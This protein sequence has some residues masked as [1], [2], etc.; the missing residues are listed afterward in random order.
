MKFDN[1][2][3]FD[4]HF[5]LEREAF[6]VNCDGSPAKT[7][8]PF[9]KSEHVDRDF[10]ENQTELITPVC[11]SIKSMLKSLSD[12]D[13]AIKRKL[14]GMGEYLWMNSNPP[15]I[16]TDE[17]IPIAR[18]EGDMAFK[19][20]YRIKL[21][22]R[23]GKRFMLYSGIHFNF[24]FSDRFIH[25]ANDKGEDFLTF[26]NKLYFRLMK[27]AARYSW[28]PV[29]LFAAS[30][31]YD[32][33]L[34]GNGLTGDGFDGYASRRSGDKGYWNKFMPVLDYTD[35]RSYIESVRQYIDDGKLISAAEL[36]LPVRLKPLGKNSLKSLEQNGIDHIELR[37][38]DLNPLS[39]I[40]IFPEE[41]D[42]THYFLIYLLSLPDFKF[43][44]K[45]QENAVKNHKAAAKYDI[46]KIKID[47]RSASDAAMDILDSMS[48]FFKNHPCVLDNISLQK[49][50]LTE[51]KRYCVKVY[52][53]FHKNFHS[54]MLDMIKRSAD[55]I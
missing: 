50:K 19:Y 34:D 7:P 6:R 14:K 18:Y 11:D 1:K 54:S 40:G 9:S 21:E 42:F 4:G 48:V 27:Q 3:M 43:T 33:S 22:R 49:R 31:V 47:G 30:P 35:I 15:R 39:P 24:S 55:N 20:D 28:L 41:A 2:Y 13:I 52:E 51:N 44:D 12:I 8:N 10:C 38:F 36:Y 23:Y 17:D 32:L 5:G 46:A 53:K 16:Q 37:M 25:A 45:L 26:K 29:L